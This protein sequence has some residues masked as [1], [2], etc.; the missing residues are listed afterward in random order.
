[1]NPP[2]PEVSP[3]AATGPAAALF[4]R[5]RRESGSAQINLL[6]RHLATM[7]A[8]ANWAW[9]RARANDDA[10]LSASIRQVVASVEFGCVS[11]I[12]LPPTASNIVQSYRTNNLSNLVRVHA[13]LAPGQRREVDCSDSEPASRIDKPL[14]PVPYSGT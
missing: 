8:F 12:A 6:W 4:D 9:T 13:I 3:Q 1:M 2:L 5:I 11:G 10:A 7:P 14:P